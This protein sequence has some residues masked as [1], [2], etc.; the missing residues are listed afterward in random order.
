MKS[1]AYPTT[2]LAC[3]EGEHSTCQHVDSE[4]N[5]TWICQCDCH[6]HDAVSIRD[7][8]A[9]FPLPPESVQVVLRYQPASSGLSF[10]VLPVE[11]TVSARGRRRHWTDV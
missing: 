9:L 7:G 4:S 5:F 1:P 3:I 6:A 8:Y 10:D 11:A 2:F